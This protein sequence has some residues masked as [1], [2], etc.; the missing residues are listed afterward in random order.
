MLFDQLAKNA[1]YNLH[2][3]LKRFNADRENMTTASTWSPVEGDLQTIL[4]AHPRPLE[5]L[6]AGAAPAFIMRGAYNPEHATALVRRFYDRGLL[7]D[8]RT[9]EKEMGRVDIGTSMG[10][11]GSDDEAFFAHAQQTHELFKALFDDYDD[12]VKFIYEML[13]ALAV[14]KKAVVGH[15]PNGRRYGPAIFRTYYEGRGHGPHMDILERDRLTGGSR[16]NYDIIRFE[17][18]LSAVLC[19]QAAEFDEKRGQTFVYRKRWDP[20]MPRGWNKSWAQD[21]ETAGIERVRIE[22]EAGDFY[23]FC[24]EFVHEIPFVQ[25]ETPRIV[26]AAFFGWSP[27]DDEM[28]VWS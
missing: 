24:P 21:A 15:E 7:F 23:V 26:L 5:E 10:S 16:C 9:R 20:N 27:D 19:F 6:L 2:T 11:R 28:F 1:F 12:P 18:Q 14:D 13:T 4:A 8:P 22:L 17:R 3:L 25:G